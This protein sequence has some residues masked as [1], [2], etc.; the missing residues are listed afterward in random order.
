MWFIAARESRFDP[1]LPGDAMNDEVPE[2]RPVIDAE[3]PATGPEH[4]STDSEAFFPPEPEPCE[5]DDVEQPRRPWQNAPTDEIPLIHPVAGT[6]AVTPHV[7]IALMGVFVYSDGVEFRLERRLRRAG[8]ALFDWQELSA[9]FME[10]WHGVSRRH[11]RLRYGVQLSNGERLT[12]GHPFLGGGD[13]S[14]VPSSPVLN[15]SGGGG[16]GDSHAYSF[17]DELWLWP[18]PPGGPLELVL[19]WPA[20]GISEARIRIDATPFAELATRATPLWP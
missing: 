9:G 19:E 2:Y 20:L 11:G 7:A 14:S 15:R 8:L 13:A 16:T 3:V 1:N 12:E 17:G 6:I 5:P 18:V 10:H 4:P